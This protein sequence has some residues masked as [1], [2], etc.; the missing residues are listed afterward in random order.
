MTGI[1]K[2]EHLREARELSPEHSFEAS[3]VVHRFPHGGDGAKI[4]SFPPGSEYASAF[5]KARI[6]AF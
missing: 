2:Q 1:V 6:L 4:Y 3:E 5:F